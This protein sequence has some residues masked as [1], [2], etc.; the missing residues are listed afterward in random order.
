MATRF[1][2][3]IP[4]TERPGQTGTLYIYYIIYIIITH[5][6]TIISSC[7]LP[8]VFRHRDSPTKIYE[9][10]FGTLYETFQQGLSIS[11]A[12]PCLG[13]RTR[14]A[15]G[16]PG[17]YQWMTYQ[18]VNQRLTDFGSGLLGLYGERIQPGSQQTHWHLGLYSIN[19]PEW[20]I[21]EQSANAYSLITVAL[22]MHNI[23]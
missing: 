9:P 22:C 13:W 3:A 14:D 18:Q 23:D 4:G 7:K 10:E 21:A 8:A 15:N 20:V 11:P 1:T 6:S 16:Q 17:S 5:T 12:G 2:V 19:R